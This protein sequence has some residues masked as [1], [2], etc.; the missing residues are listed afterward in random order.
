[1]VQTVRETWQF[2]PP[3][4][5][6]LFVSGLQAL[7]VGSSVVSQLLD[8]SSS[9]ASYVECIINGNITTGGSGTFTSGGYIE[10][11]LQPSLDNVI[12]PGLVGSSANDISIALIQVNANSN[13][14]PKTFVLSPGLNGTL[15]P[16]NKL[17]FFNNTGGTLAGYSFAYNFETNT[18]G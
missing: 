11:F 7:P 17:R 6:N 13:V 4:H 1:M 18:L 8:S 12:Y 2:A 15:A 14:Y 9:A 5:G 10:V 3:G 16:Y